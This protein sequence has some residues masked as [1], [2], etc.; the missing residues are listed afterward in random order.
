M[1][2][3]QRMFMKLFCLTLFL[4]VTTGML[5]AQDV[6]KVSPESHKVLLNNDQVR[7]LQVRLKPGEK[8][9]MHSHPAS[10]LYYLTNAKVRITLP[11][12]KT[13]VRECKAGTA[14]FAPPVTHAVEN[15]GKT[16]LIE[17]QTELKTSK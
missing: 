7:V 11:D 3:L 1:T 15:I 13:Q 9:G 17:V 16:D 6:E 12:G 5:L 4:A 8:V 14:A 10:V 2:N